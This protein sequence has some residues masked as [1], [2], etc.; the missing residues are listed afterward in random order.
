VWASRNFSR[1]AKPRCVC[2]GVIFEMETV[3][4][5]NSR[6]TTATE[7]SKLDRLFV[8]DSFIAANVT[9]IHVGSIRGLSEAEQIGSI[10]RFYRFPIS[11]LATLKFQYEASPELISRV[12]YDIYFL[13][14]NPF[15]RRSRGKFSFIPFNR[16]SSVLLT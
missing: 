8:R 9:L 15:I 13:P 6:W 11:R 16:A 12:S 7:F 14:F 10:T 2:C 4:C 1:S 3:D 5:N